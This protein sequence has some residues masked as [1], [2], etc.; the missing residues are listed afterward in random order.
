MEIYSLVNGLCYLDL[1]KSLIILLMLLFLSILGYTYELFHAEQ[2]VDY[3]EVVCVGG[4]DTSPIVNL[5]L[6]GANGI[7]QITEYFAMFCATPV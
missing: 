3:G 5:F 2:L 4:E 6:F 1:E 7:L